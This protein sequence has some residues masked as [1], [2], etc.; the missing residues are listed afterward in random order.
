MQV[1]KG[2]LFFQMQFLLGTIEKAPDLYLDELQ[3]IL[4]A[5]CGRTV[6]K[7]TIWCTLHKTGFT[8]KK[9]KS[10]THSLSF[11]FLLALDYPYC[12][13]T[14][15]GEMCRLCCENYRRLSRATCLCWRELHWLP[16]NILWS[17]LVNPRYQGT[18]QSILHLWSMV[19]S[20]SRNLS[21]SVITNDHAASLFSQLSLSKI[22][23][24]VTS[25][26][27][28]FVQNRSSVLLKAYLITCNLFRPQTRW[29]SW[30]IV[31]FTSIKRFKN[32]FMNG[33]VAQ[34]TIPMFACFSLKSII[35]NRI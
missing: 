15:S 24:T 14:L 28:L 33:I 35:P 19:R 30:T 34:T 4:A 17:C 9:V 3:E 11:L 23:C 32:W 21:L 20:Y 18:A 8:M 6:S 12:C 13:W 5:L 29:S 7:S 31:K 16:H 10:S 22:F 26:K 25:L 2:Q 27:G 1:A